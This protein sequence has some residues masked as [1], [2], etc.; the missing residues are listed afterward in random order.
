MTGLEEALL[1]HLIIGSGSK[2]KDFVV[3]AEKDLRKAIFRALVLAAQDSGLP[4][5]VEPT[6]VAN[7]LIEGRTSIDT[8]PSRLSGAT[9]DVPLALG[10]ASFAARLS[11]LLPDQLISDLNGL[12]IA[13][14]KLF[15]AFG[16][17]L[18]EVIRAASVNGNSA[19]QPLASRIEASDAAR[20]GNAIASALGI[21]LEQTLQTLDE[22]KEE[23]RLRTLRRLDALGVPDE[24]RDQLLESMEAIPLPTLGDDPLSA[25]TADGGSGKST[26][27]ERLH[28]RAIDRAESDPGAPLPVFVQANDINDPLDQV[29]KRTWGAN[30]GLPARGIDLVLDGLEE[31]GVARAR[32]LLL[33]LRSMLRDEH[34]PVRSAIVTRRPVDLDIEMTELPLTLLTEDEADALVRYLSD[35]AHPTA[36]YTPVIREAIRRPFF[37]IAVGL[38]LARSPSH[39]LPTPSTVIE[40]VARRALRDVQWEEVANLLGRAA[41]ASVDAHHGPVPLSRLSITRREEEVLRQ[42]RLVRIE[43]GQL[44]FQVALLAEWF[45]AEHLR[46][47]LDLVSELVGDSKRLD[48][49]RYPLV[50]FVESMGSDAVDRVLSE[51]TERAPAMA[52]WVLT[53]PDPFNRLGFGQTPDPDDVD[54]DVLRVGTR[55][56]SAYAALGTGLEPLSRG[57]RLY[58]SAGPPPL[59]LQIASEYEVVRYY[60]SWHKPGAGI[61]PVLNELPSGPAHEVFRDWLSMTGMTTP[62]GHPAWPWLHAQSELRRSL[63]KAIAAGALFEGSPGYDAEARWRIASSVAGKE[64]NAGVA[65]IARSELVAILEYRDHLLANAGVASARDD[66]AT[67]AV[68]KLVKE[69]EAGEEH[70]VSRPWALPDNLGGG[71]SWVW[72]LWSD[73][74]LLERAKIVTRIALQIYKHA[75]DEYLVHFQPQLRIASDWPV[76]VVGFMSPGAMGEGLMG[77][78]QFLWYLDTNATDPEPEWSLVDDIRPVMERLSEERR[79][80]RWSGGELHGIYSPS[81]AT[82]F[83]RGL[84]WTDLHDW[85]WTSGALPQA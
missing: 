84:L 1:G 16:R 42:S 48:L 44:T 34:S 38:S 2:L 76:R 67:A 78:P 50:L 80:S 5:G 4:D 83:A 3:G 53:Q 39:L 47:N 49:W 72:G 60:Y 63:E 9:G 12:G 74:A 10:E 57:W 59:G 20:T 66:A 17:R 70:E 23:S 61:L 22:M 29:L 14:P 13:L 27:G 6:W 28:R 31:V 43:A 73:S 69:L 11:G 51:L 41:A 19:L 54:Q 64:G 37:A 77:Q 33:D 81:P 75:V 8:V 24:R 46:E 82:E 58:E 52:G 7:V 15:E 85:G 62:T 30:V 55:W 45:A 32:S 21:N 26:M 65:S 36:L 35:Q 18:P 79:V 71:H 40:S 25:L 68:R 56:R